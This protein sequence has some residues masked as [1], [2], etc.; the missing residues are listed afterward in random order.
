MV[1]DL[2][3]RLRDGAAREASGKSALWDSLMTEAADALEAKDK[4]IA[5]LEAENERLRDLLDH[6]ESSAYPGYTKA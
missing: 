1:S 5:E 3:E 2:I 6:P 4:R